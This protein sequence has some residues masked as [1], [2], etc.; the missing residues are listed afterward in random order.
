M[1]ADKTVT[2]TFTLK[3]YTLVTA[4]VG[5]GVVSLE[6]AGG[7]YDAGTVV[8]A[9]AVPDGHW[10]FTSWSGDVGGATNPVT[11]T[12]DAGKAVTATF[13]IKQYDLISGTVGMGSIAVDPGGG[14]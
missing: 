8:T 9:T 2:A 5:N 13:T 11:V 1:D 10:D 6:P 4:T 14:Q 7:L 3:Q 12:I